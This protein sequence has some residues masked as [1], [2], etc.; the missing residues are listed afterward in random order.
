MLPAAV[1]P[2]QKVSFALKAVVATGEGRLRW[3][4]SGH[5]APVEW[6]YTVEID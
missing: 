4:P 3:I 2:G 5:L 6:D 1:L